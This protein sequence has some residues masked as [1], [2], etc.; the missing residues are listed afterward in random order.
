[1]R[2]TNALIFFILLLPTLT[3][4]QITIQDVGDRWKDKVDSAITLIKKTDTVSYQILIDNCKDIE[5]IIGKYSTTK[6]PNTIA[7]TTKDMS[8]NSINNIA[9]VLVH[10]SYHL[11]IYNNKIRYSSSNEEEIA[12]YEREYDFLCKLPDVEDWLFLNAMN[13]IILYR[14]PK[15]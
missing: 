15:R 2:I 3:F 8:L 7:I 13:N 10:E 11:F 1:M 12:C 6:L 4:G 5:F 14:I 9:A